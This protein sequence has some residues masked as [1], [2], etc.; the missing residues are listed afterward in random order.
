MLLLLSLPVPPPPPPPPLLLEPLTGLSLLTTA[1]VFA[2]SV[3]AGAWLVLWAG[4]NREL[5]RERW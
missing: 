5:I 2:L 4:L 1:S 3:D